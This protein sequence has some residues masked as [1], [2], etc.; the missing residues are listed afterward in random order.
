MK[1]KIKIVSAK[2]KKYMHALNRK[3]ILFFFFFNKTKKN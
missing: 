2:K 1:I 3:N